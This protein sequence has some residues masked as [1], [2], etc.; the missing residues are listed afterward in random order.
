M[1]HRPVLFALVDIGS[2]GIERKELTAF[3]DRIVYY[4]RTGVD[5]GGC[6]S[7]VRLVCWDTETYEVRE[8]RSVE[9]VLASVRFH[10]RGGTYI[11]PMLERLLQENIRNNILVV[12]SDGRIEDLGEPRVQEALRQISMRAGCCMFVSTDK[13]VRLP[14]RWRLIKIK[15]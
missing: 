7:E 1:W 10:G 12:L 9:D 15:E 5:R 8:V 4:L 14:P 6:L 13:E 2:R 11:T 3:A